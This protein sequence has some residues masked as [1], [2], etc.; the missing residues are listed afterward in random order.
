MVDWAEGETSSSVPHW[1]QTTRLSARRGSAAAAGVAAALGAARLGLAVVPEGPGE[2]GGKTSSRRK[3]CRQ[4]RQT[5]E[6]AAEGSCW[7][8]P[9]LGHATRTFWGF[10]AGFQQ[11]PARP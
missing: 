4:F 2:A 6:Y 9:H 10:M 5:V 7:V 8:C 3:C 1:K 11:P